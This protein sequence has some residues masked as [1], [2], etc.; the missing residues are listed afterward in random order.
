MANGNRREQAQAPAGQVSTTA[1]DFAKWLVMMLA[2]GSYDGEQVVDPAALAEAHIP[3]VANEEQADPA[4][5]TPF[6]GYGLGIRTDATGRVRDGFSGAYAQGAAA[7]FT[8]LPSEDLGIAVFTNAYPLGAAEGLAYDFLDLVE[9]GQNPVDWSQVWGEKFEAALA[10]GAEADAAQQDVPL[11]TG[12]AAAALDDYVGVY[13]NVYY[14][15]VTIAR[16]G[17]DALVATVGPKTVEFALVAYNGNVFGT[18]DGK[19]GVV[20]AA[21][22]TLADGRGATVEF[23]ALQAPDN[24][25]FRRAAGAV[26]EP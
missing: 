10:G 1:N 20:P 19:G 2:E 6:Y 14:G 7:H 13:E 23:A 17:A 8:L 22:F 9:L 11:L 26:S 24:S 25:V 15:P 12:V 16:D 4:A 18:P 21:E 5:R 3:R